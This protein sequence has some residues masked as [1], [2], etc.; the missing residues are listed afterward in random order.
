M[1]V[2]QPLVIASQED[3]AAVQELPAL[4]LADSQMMPYERGVA[5][6]AQ[7]PLQR[8]KVVL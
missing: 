3:L 4:G 2:G 8:S 6:S 1:K 5:A 7:Q